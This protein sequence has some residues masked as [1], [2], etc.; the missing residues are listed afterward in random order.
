MQYTLRN[1]PAELDEALRARETYGKKSKRGCARSSTSRYRL[2][3]RT[4][5]GGGSWSG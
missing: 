3:R 4:A 1:V 5:K 2:N